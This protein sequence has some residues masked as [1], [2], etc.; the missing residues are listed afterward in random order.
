MVLLNPVLYYSYFFNDFNI[1]VEICSVIIERVVELTKLII[2]NAIRRSR[3]IKVK[4][5]GIVNTIRS[6]VKVN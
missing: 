2:V 4:A 6:R 1:F 5:R 3:R